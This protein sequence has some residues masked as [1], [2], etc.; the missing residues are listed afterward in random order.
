LEHLSLRDLRALLEFL[1]QSYA[2]QDREGFVTHLL[3]ATPKLIPSDATSFNEIDPPKAKSEN[4]MNPPEVQTP[5][6]ARTWERFMHQQPILANYVRTGDGRASKLSDFLAKP[7][8]HDL[9]IYQDLYRGMGAESIMAVFLPTPRP[10]SVALAFHRGRRDFSECERLILNLLIPHLLAVYQTTGAMDR[11]RHKTALLE[12]G[13]AALDQGLIVVG[14]L[15]QIVQ[16]NATAQDL[17]TRYFNMSPRHPGRLPDVLQRWTSHEEDCLRPS[18]DP[19]PPRRPLVIEHTNER[20]VVRLIGPDA[21]GQRL[22][23][24]EYQALT[25]DL[26]ILEEL[27]LTR[28]EAQVLSWLA[29]GKTNGEIAIILGTRPRTVAKHLEHIFPKIG[30]ETRTAAVSLAISA[31]AGR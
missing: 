9:G 23:L 4:W 17:L 22:L 2:V 24:L 16:S 6:R 28:R 30:V 8:F 25:P 3:A 19:P 7:R 14:S 27:G 12:D 15:G 13:L 31:S 1:K 5:E 21:T 26:T 11:L 18:D 20:L 29:Q 10:L